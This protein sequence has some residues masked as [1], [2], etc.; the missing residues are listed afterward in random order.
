MHAAGSPRL[1]VGGVSARHAFSKVA[2]AFSSL[3]NAPEID[4]DVL[5]PALI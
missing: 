3:G 2:E 5:E 1:A 4:A